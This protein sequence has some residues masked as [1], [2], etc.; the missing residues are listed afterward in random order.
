MEIMNYNNYVST[1]HLVSS[2][3]NRVSQGASDVPS[4]QEGCAGMLKRAP[5]VALRTPVLRSPSAIPVAWDIARPSVTYTAL[6]S[7]FL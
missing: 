6:L 7:L 2:P 3:R 1:L 5:P 4:S